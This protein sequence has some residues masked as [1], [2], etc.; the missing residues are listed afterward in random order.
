M[1]LLLYLQHTLQDTYFLCLA[2]IWNTF[3]DCM[4]KNN[5]L[6]LIWGHVCVLWSFKKLCFLWFLE[7]RKK[8]LTKVSHF[9]SVSI[10]K[11]KRKRSTFIEGLCVSLQ[12]WELPQRSRWKMHLGLLA[13]LTG[14]DLL[15]VGGQNL[16]NLAPARPESVKLA[17][18]LYWWWGML[19]NIVTKI[20]CLG[21]AHTRAALSY[22]LY[23]LRGF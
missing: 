22:I 17:I 21:Q 23:I 7:H 13:A 11:K 15:K 12:Q 14:F 4:G 10:K 1:Q 19:N 9:F 2:V 3:Y 18:W 5:C 6:T 20:S 8:A 16:E